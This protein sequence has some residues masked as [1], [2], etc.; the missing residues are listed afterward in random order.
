MDSLKNKS[1]FITGSSR[2]I[3]RALALKLADQGCNI[4]LHYRKNIEEAESAEQEILKKG[5]KVWKYAADL[6]DLN[7]LQNLHQQIL[8]DHQSLDIFVSNAAATAFKPLDQLK[9]HHIEKTLNITV[10]T[11]IL[12][13]NAFKPL[14][15]PG[16]KVITVSGIDTIKYCVNHGLLAAAKSALETLTR[17]YAQ[18]WRNEQIYVQGVNPGLVDTDSIKIYWGAEYEKKKAEL[19][20]LIPPHGLMPT[21]Q[22]ADLILFLLS[23]AANWMNGETMV[24]EGGVGFRMPVFSN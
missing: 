15:K 24:A 2:G 4:L 16:S 7:Q 10:S 1:A 6:S 12:T 8:K 3:G 13:M 9:Q 11:F 14:L 22:V 5:V 20:E 19:A 21:D 17:Y 18:E 23:D